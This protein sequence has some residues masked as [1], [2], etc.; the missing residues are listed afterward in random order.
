[1]LKTTIDSISS[2]AMQELQ[3]QSLEI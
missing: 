1:M 2:K 3:Q